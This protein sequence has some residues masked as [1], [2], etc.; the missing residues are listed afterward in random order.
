MFTF[1]QASCHSHTE[2]FYLIKLPASIILCDYPAAVSYWMFTFCQAFYHSHTEW[3]YFIKVPASVLLCNYVLSCIH[4]IKYPVT[5]I[6]SD[7]FT[8]LF[9]TYL[10]LFCITSCCCVILNIYILSSILLLSYRE[11]LPASVAQMCRPTG[12]Q[13]VAGSTPAEVGNILSWR[14]IMKYL[15]R[16]FSPFR[17]FKKDSCQFLVKECAQ[18]WLTT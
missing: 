16:S 17:W 14:L 9:A 8:K 6:L 1:C 18:Y 10:W 12:D 7:L 5:D 13:E 11:I 15:L 3:L 2:W 4:F